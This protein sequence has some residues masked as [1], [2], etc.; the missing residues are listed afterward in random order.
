MGDRVT[1]SLREEGLVVVFIHP[2]DDP[3]II[4]GQG[5]VGL[6]MMEQASHLGLGRGCSYAQPPPSSVSD[7]DFWRRR[8]PEQPAMDVVIAPVGGGGML[9]GIA[10]AVKGLDPRTIV[11]GAEPQGESPNEVVLSS[12]AAY[13]RGTLYDNRCR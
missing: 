5:T 1:R 12:T 13:Q 10:S 2:Y 3:A 4:A 8:S 11:V 9:S 7:N 6:E